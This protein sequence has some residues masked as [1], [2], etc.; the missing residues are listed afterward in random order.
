MPTFIKPKPDQSDWILYPTLIAVTG[1]CLVQMS[2][3]V[4]TMN[5]VVTDHPVWAGVV[6]CLAVLSL[7]AT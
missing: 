4:S 7:V 5:L 3:I 1:R 6:F 2:A